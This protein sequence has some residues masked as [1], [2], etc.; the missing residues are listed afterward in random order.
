MVHGTQLIALGALFWPLAGAVPEVVDLTYSRYRGVALKNGVT[1]WLGMRY[2]AA[3]VGDLR[4]MPPAD[5]PS[6]RGV[7]SAKEVSEA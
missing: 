7:Q 3:P 1:Q 5:P 4:F 2:A 6:T